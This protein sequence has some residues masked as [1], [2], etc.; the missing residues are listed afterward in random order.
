M[1]TIAFIGW[2][3]TAFG[4]LV[5]ILL[6]P[7]GFVPL[8]IFP[9]VYS[10]YRALIALAFFLVYVR[11]RRILQA[12][13]WRLDR[14]PY[15]LS[16]HPE[17]PHGEKWIEFPNPE[18]PGE[19]IPLHFLSHY[20]V[21]WWGRRMAPRAKPELKAELDPIWFAGD[22][23]FFGV[24]AVSS[25][26]PSKA[27]DLQ[28]RRLHVLTQPHAFFSPADHNSWQAS[29]Q[30]VARAQQAGARSGRRRQVREAQ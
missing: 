10:G 21:N 29:A 5:L 13:S 25:G 6:L 17:S 14:A 22:P 15:G 18:R 27:A 26:P 4:V 1:N 23:R 12:Y 24:I 3:L 9:M 11:M 28:P 8:L 19:K 2:I 20:R 7:T 16:Q 30:D